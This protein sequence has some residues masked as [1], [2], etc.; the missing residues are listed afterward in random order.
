MIHFLPWMSSSGAAGASVRQQGR[1]AQGRRRTSITGGGAGS[2]LKWLPAA[3]A[4]MQA[5]FA[6]RPSCLKNLTEA[7]QGTSG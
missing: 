2:A 7:M 5:L 1:H 3:C 4:D 6:Q